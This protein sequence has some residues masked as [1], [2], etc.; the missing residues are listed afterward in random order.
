[1]LARRERKDPTTVAVRVA[2]VDPLPMFRHGVT[3]VLSAAGH[4]VD[5]PADLLAWAVRRTSALVL[6]T[7]AGE[8]EWCLLGRLCE[9]SGLPA[10][11]A[12]TDGVSAVLGARAIRAGARSVLPRGVAAPVLQRTVEATIDG[13]SVMPAA[14]TAL[15][16]S[17]AA[18][19]VP[20]VSTAGA[21]W[22][23]QLASGATVAQL[24]AQ[25]GYSERAMFRLLR[26]LYQEIGVS[27][28]VEAIMRAREWGWL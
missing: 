19:D 17:A 3:A 28:R 9:R 13:Q 25:T 2:V 22:L 4:P 12:L 21:A 18:G 26:S 23:R 10:V 7:M 6:L 1:V 16:A 8:T 11:V 14:V 15:L 27:T 24:A 5:T 20:Q